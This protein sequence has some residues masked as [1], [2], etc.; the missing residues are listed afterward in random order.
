M[1]SQFS[2][3]KYSIV[4]KSEEDVP[5]NLNFW[6]TE[7]A[8]ILEVEYNPQQSYFPAFGDLV[9]YLSNEAVVEVQS[10]ENSDYKMEDTRLAWHIGELDSVHS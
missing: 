4:S 6:G 8:A 1:P 10:V 7:H 3:L 2:A 9:I 5:F